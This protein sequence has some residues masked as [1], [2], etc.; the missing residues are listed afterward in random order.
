MIFCI[1]DS[2]S[3]SELAEIH[4]AYAHSISHDRLHVKLVCVSCT[5][6]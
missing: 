5:V 2:N 1:G 4:C 3:G 6:E